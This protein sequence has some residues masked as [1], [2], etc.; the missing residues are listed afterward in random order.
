[1]CVRPLGRLGVRVGE[2]GERFVKPNPVW[3]VRPPVWASG[4]LDPQTQVS[5]AKLLPFWSDQ[6]H[7]CGAARFL[8]GSPTSGP[9]LD[10]RVRGR[11]SQIVTLLF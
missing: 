4:L 9:P 8:S 6:P 11:G 3:P 1:M 10:R 2:C 7:P 5:Q